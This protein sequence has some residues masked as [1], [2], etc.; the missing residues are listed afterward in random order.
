MICIALSSKDNEWPN[1]FQGKPVNKILL[2]YSPIITPRAMA[3]QLCSLDPQKK[4]VKI[5]PGLD[6]K[7]RRRGR[8]KILNNLNPSNSNL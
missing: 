3:K 4:A 8:P 5:Q 6:K 2:E 7:T 1:K